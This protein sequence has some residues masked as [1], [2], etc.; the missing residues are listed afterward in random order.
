MTQNKILAKQI[1]HL[2]Q[3]LEEDRAAS[4][5]DPKSFSD[6]SVVSVDKDKKILSMSDLDNERRKRL[7]VDVPESIF[8][9]VGIYCSVNST[10]R[11]KLINEMLLRQLKKEGFIQ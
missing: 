9:A 5:I 8:K 3:S 11:H 6:K 10:T 4:Q 7:S 2:K 1:T